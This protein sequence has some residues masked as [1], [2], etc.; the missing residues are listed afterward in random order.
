MKIAFLSCDFG[1]PM[2][3]TAGSSTHTQGTVQAIRQLGHQ[4]KVFSSN[5]G[6][7]V[8]ETENTGFYGVPLTGF[9]QEVE[10]LLRRER[11]AIAEHVPPE[12]RALLHAEYVQKALLPVLTEFQPDA[13]YERYSLF[14][15]GGIELANHFGIPHLLEVNAPLSEQATKYRQLIINRTADHLEERIINS[16]DAVLVTTQA[17]ADYAMQLGVPKERISVKPCG[18]DPDLFNPKISG[19]AVRRRHNLR[20]KQVIG[21]VGSLKQWHDLDT[22]VEATQL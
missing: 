10:G 22:L 16:A 19:R 14:A 20:E 13:I 2:F 5:L 12:L 6:G 11:Q 18:V 15:Y 17:L 4:V 21:F 8:E 7:P 1:V 3:G 9:A